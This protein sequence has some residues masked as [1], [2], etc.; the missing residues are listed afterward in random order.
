MR[1]SDWSSDVC[2][3]DLLLGVLAKARRG[4][5]LDRRARQLDR[6]ADGLEAAA[7][8]MRHLDDGAA[9]AQR[10]VV[11]QLLHVHDR[12]AGDV[13][14]VETLHD[15][16]LVPGPGPFLNDREALVDL[17]QDRTSVE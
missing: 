4:L 17:R 13:V 10:L 11:H 12:A 9:G 3:S 14:L 2:S 1:I 16:E 5:H 7:L 15:L 8:R 6:T